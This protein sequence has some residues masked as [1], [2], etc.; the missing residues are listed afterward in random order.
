LKK[1][2]PLELRVGHGPP[3]A[4]GPGRGPGSCCAHAAADAI[5]KIKSKATLLAFHFFI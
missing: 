2:C 4:A 1:Y 3:A 5:P